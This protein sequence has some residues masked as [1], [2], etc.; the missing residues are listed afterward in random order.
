M[1]RFLLNMQ[2][3]RKKKMEKNKVKKG[4]NFNTDDKNFFLHANVKTVAMS[5]KVA[6]S[7]PIRQ[8]K[9]EK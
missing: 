1:I 9:C 7:C 2:K 3:Y 6:F 8:R 4:N 5:T